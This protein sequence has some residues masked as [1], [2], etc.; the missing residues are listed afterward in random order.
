[1][2]IGVATFD[3]EGA[4]A[5]DRGGLPSRSIRSNGFRKI[6][7]GKCWSSKGGGEGSLSVASG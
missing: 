1:M 3:E 4:T 2:A 6:V 7:V 5:G